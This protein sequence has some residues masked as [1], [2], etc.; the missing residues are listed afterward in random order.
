MVYFLEWSLE[1]TN[2]LTNSIETLGNETKI[3]KLLSIVFNR[4]VTACKR[5]HRKIT[6]NAVPKAGR[7]GVH[8][9]VRKAV[10]IPPKVQ[11][12]K[13]ISD[14]EL[15]NLELECF[16]EIFSDP[17]NALKAVHIPPKGKEVEPISDEELSKLELECFDVI[18]SDHKKDEYDIF[19]NNTPV[20]I[21]DIN[22]FHFTPM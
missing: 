10:H 6:M 18:F 21:F 22:T 7:N 17:V 16:E 5:K 12:Y 19:M 11:D 13:R 14:E 15:F 3:W 8:K 4:S 9:A 20:D 1:D 2:L